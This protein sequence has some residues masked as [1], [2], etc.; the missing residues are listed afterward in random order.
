VKTARCDRTEAWA[1]LAGH[2]QAHGREFDLREAFARDPGRFAS[3]GVEAPEVYADL[4]KNLIDVAT[5]HFL[6][7]LAAECQIEARRDA[8]LRGDAINAT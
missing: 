3:F 4:S 5:R 2:Y 6:L 8:M 7:D 1:A